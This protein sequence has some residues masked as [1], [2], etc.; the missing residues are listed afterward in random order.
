RLPVPA[1]LT[2]FLLGGGII[3]GSFL[4]LRE[5]GPGDDACGDKIELR[6]SAAPQ[7]ADVLAGIADRYRATSPKVGGRRVAGSVTSRA[8]RDTVAQLSTGWE[9]PAVAPA[10]HHRPA[11]VPPPSTEPP[12]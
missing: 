2:A 7:L 5:D 10:L 9:A 4:A 1:T 11:N 12:D 6:I 3:V 8:S